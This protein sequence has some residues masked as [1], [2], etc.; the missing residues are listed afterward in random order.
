MFSY[1]PI[2]KVAIC[3]VYKSY[4]VLGASSQER[5]LRALLHRL[6][7]DELKVTIE[8]LSSYELRSAAELREHKPRLED[9]C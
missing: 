7:G 5:H 9:K 2:Y 3:Y 1:N 4:I 6:L 8:L